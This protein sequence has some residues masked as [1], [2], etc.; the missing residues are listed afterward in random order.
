MWK[1]LDVARIPLP[2]RAPVRRN[3]LIWN[4]RG[5]HAKMA[6]SISQ[7]ARTLFGNMEARR[8]TP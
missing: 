2:N 8:A 1:S 6:A 7:D 5:H 4:T 3:G